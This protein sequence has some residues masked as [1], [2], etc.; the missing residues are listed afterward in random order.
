M[1]W[2]VLLLCHSLYFLSFTSFPVIHFIL[3]PNWTPT[4]L[5]YQGKPL[6]GNHYSNIDNDDTDNDDQ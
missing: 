2:T 5:F 3:Y 6:T 1:T 4:C